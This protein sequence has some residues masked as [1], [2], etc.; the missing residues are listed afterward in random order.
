[1]CDVF[2]ALLTRATETPDCMEKLK[3]DCTAFL[4]VFAAS[5]ETWPED[6]QEYA[7]PI[8][9]IVRGIYCLVDP[10]P[11]R[12]EGQPADLDFISPLKPGPKGNESSHASQSDISSNSMMKVLQMILTKT[13]G[14]VKL[15][16]DYSKFIGAEAT[17]GQEL[18]KLAVRTDTLQ[19]VFSRS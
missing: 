5:L 14:W 9:N 3:R 13:P 11:S 18:H 19:R 1:M 15:T 4:S 16:D 8:V 2:I 10:E 17:S 7:S 12:Y 6:I